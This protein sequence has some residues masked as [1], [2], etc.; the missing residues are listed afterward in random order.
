MISEDEY[1]LFYDLDRSKNVDFPYNEYTFDLDEIENSDCVA[2][3][4][5]N[6]HDLPALAEAPHIPDVFKC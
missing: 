4:R 6:K 5:V 3:F 1:L 2:K